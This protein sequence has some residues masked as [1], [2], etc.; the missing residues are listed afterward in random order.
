[1]NIEP[2]D[3]RRF[4][5]G[6]TT[7]EESNKI[8]QWLSV[9]QNEAVAR[10]ILGDL[11]TNNEIHLKGQKPDFDTMLLKT[12]FRIPTDSI[13]QI[14]KHSRSN[15]NRFIQLF[16]RVAAVLILPLMLFTAYLYFQKPVVP[17]SPSAENA[18]FGIREIYTK[19][20]TRTSL[21]LADGTRVWL[22]DGTTF[23]YPE[24]F[25]GAK[26]E[27]YV[28]GE[29]YFE[30]E[31]DKQHP[32]VVNNPMMKT[33][34]TGTHFNV[35]G[36]SKDQFF[37]ATLLEGKIQL[38]SKS[39]NAELLPGEQLQFNVDAKKMV[40]REVKSS[41][42]IGWIDGRLIIQN[43]RLELALKK[44][45]RWYNIDI[46][47]D[48]K[49]ISDYELTCTL[50]NEKVDQCMNLISNALQIRYRVEKIDNKKRIHLLKK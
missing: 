2:N 44:I 47:M 6:K 5:E 18:G 42:A 3:I 27:V 15:V 13:N 22:N 31:A 20:G 46:V 14:N 9:P 43:E 8:K 33:L 24:Q 45:S 1:M 25:T 17:V 37:E 16:Y 12:K 21:Q 32:F 49:S 50:E 11:W 30:V 34:V 39:G 10:M 23:R 36:Y 40:Q 7:P 38:E 29:A 26:R 41:S 28:D 35:N 4:L 48:D 19:P